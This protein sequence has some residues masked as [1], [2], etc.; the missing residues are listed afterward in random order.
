MKHCINAKSS[1]LLL[2][3]SLILMSCGTSKFTQSVIDS[4]VKDKKAFVETTDGTI[5]EANDAKMKSPLFG[6][7][8]IELDN[9]VKIPIK[10]V[11]A[12]QTYAAYYRLSRL[13]FAPRF[14]KGLI[15]MYF[16][17]YQ[18]QE[19]ENVPGSQRSQMRTRTKTIYFMQKGDT[20]PLQNFSIDL[21]REYVKDYAPAMEFMNVFD[22]N[23]KKYRMWSWINTGAVIGGAILC[24][25]SIDGQT[26]KVNEPVGY[27]GLA[28]FTGGMINGFINKFRKGANGKNL[29]LAIDTYNYQ[30]VKKKQ[31]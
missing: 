11:V 22:N 31:K 18:V 19:W 29:E 23:R 24:A 1:L 20:T 28:L 15:N 26:Q 7:T 13:G 12:Y 27:S 10:D 30:T 25:V 2:I 3:I 4:R 21:T 5:I 16:T 8:T 14:K 9:G 6:K 17:Q